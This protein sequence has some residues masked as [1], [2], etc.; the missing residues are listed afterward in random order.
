MRHYQNF[1]KID[2]FLKPDFRVGEGIIKE[3]AGIFHQ[4]Y[5]YRD[6]LLVGRNRIHQNKSWYYLGPF[7]TSKV[8]LFAKVVFDYK[9]LIFL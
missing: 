6:V 5:R 2:S 3:E 8:E 7:Q 4:I 9:P 1:D